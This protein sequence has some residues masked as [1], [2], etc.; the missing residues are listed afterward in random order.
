MSLA[1]AFT[2][3]RAKQPMDLKDTGAPQRS[4]TVTRGLGYSG[5]IRNKISS[6]MELT[7]TTNM[8]AY[9]APDLYPLSAR[10][11]S[12][13]AS[14]SSD[15][16]SDARTNASS[17]PTSPDVAS[18]AEHSNEPEPNHLS[19][20]FTAPGQKPPPRVNEAPSIPKRAPSHTKKASFDNLAQK[21]AARYSN[22]SLQTA[23]SK[24][25]FSLS[26]SSSTS[27]TATSVSS[28]SYSRSKPAAPSVPA[29]PITPAVTVS[30]PVRQ[31]S[32]RR[33]DL[34]PSNHPFGQELAQVSEIAEDYGVSDKLDL[35]REE[36]KE[37]ASKGLCCFKAEE[38]AAEVN[39]LFTTFFQS[40][41][42]RPQEIWI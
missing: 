24:G 21:Q 39:S 16:E 4:N 34:S 10:S 3:R 42:H 9:N 41:P 30:T 11:V 38:Y 13:S 33:H 25:S 20:Y 26:R 28:N 18:I 23:S 27:T 29:S 6:P 31:R 19:C 12:S 7:H 35:V 1:R 32:T 15:D 8:L 14:K 17:P 36:Q 37:L 5:S 2:T 22:Q 40:E